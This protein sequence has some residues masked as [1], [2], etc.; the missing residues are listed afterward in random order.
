MQIVWKLFENTIEAVQV[1]WD[2][3]KIRK[4]L[5]YFVQKSR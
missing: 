2:E 4:N 5:P 1:F 3:R